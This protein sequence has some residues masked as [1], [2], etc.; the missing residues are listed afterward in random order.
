MPAHTRSPM[1]IDPDNYPV[2]IIAAFVI[3]MILAMAFG[4][5]PEHGLQ[6]PWT[7]HL[8][9]SLVLTSPWE[10]QLMT[11]NTTAKKKSTLMQI[12]QGMLWFTV[13]GTFLIGIRH[14]LPGE[15]ASG[16]WL[17]LF[18]RLVPSYPCGSML[19]PV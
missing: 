8:P 14:L 7:R 13:I 9:P 18:V 5:R 4:F 15:A 11:V 1:K 16:G 6:R 19:L 2:I 12:R 10:T 3:G 17:M